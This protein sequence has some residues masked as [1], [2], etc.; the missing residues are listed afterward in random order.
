M[1]DADDRQAG[2]II[3]RDLGLFNKAAVFFETQIDPLIRNKIEQVASSWLE[4][5]DWVG[6]TDVTENFNDLWVA[7]RRWAKGE[8]DYVAWFVLSRRANSAGSSYQV[9]DLFGVGQAEF[10]FRFKVE[11]NAFGGA[12]AWK[13][14]AEGLS[15]LRERL[16]G[17]GWSPEGND[18]FFRPAVLPADKLVAAWESDDW[19]EALAPLVQAL[20]GLEGDVAMFDAIIEGARGH[21][22]VRASLR[23][24]ETAEVG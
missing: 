18:A 22:A 8:G 15:D 17:R 5:R 6:E 19:E 7:P 24:A 13:A 20:D 3:L 2:T 1:A 16:A 14:Y 4:T 12:R 23:D 9:A 21:V 10:G 11:R